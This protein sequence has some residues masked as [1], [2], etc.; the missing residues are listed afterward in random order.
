M[1]VRLVLSDR[2]TYHQCMLT[3]MGVHAVWSPSIVEKIPGHRTDQRAYGKTGKD[4]FLCLDTR[5]SFLDLPV[6]LVAANT[7]CV[8]QEWKKPLIT[9]N[10]PALRLEGVVGKGL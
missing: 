8:G 4:P 10:G 7:H 6:P 9:P 3:Q 1:A 5:Q 2:V